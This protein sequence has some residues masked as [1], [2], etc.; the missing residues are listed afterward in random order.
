M[1][2]G[3]GKRWSVPLSNEKV[4]YPIQKFFTPLFDT[5]MLKAPFWKSWFFENFHSSKKGVKNFLRG[6]KLLFSKNMELQLSPESKIRFISQKLIENE[7]FKVR[8]YLSIFK[9]WYHLARNDIMSCQMISFFENRQIYS[10]FELFV[11]NQF[12]RYESN[13]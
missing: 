7:K 8:V 4:F 10:N 2:F 13:F 12:L 11:L 3:S 6:K 1:I 9:K 5:W